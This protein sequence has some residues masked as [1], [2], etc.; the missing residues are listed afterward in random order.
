MASMI[1]GRLSANRITAIFHI[2]H[3]VRFL[4]IVGGSGFLIFLTLAVQ[5]P[6]EHK[7][8]ALFATCLAF[9][10]AGCGTS[11]MAPTFYTAGNRRSPLPSAVVVGQLAFVNNA[12]ILV[13]KTTIAWVAQFTGSLA[14]ALA[15]PGALLI[16]VAYFARAV[17]A[18]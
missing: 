12:V 3:T 14:I 1:L 2:H 17:K 11:L 15:I 18:D 4:A 16:T 9:T 10:F 6:A 7:N 5:I 13:L 8:W